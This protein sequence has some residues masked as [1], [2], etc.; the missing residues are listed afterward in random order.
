MLRQI[1]PNTQP[2]WGVMTLQHMVEHMADALRMAN[3]KDQY[4]QLITPEDKI[5]KM[6]AFILSDKP[7]REN[8]PNPLLPKVPGPC[9]NGSLSESIEELEKEI[10]D[11][12]SYFEQHPDARLLNPFFGYLNFDLYL[13]LLAKHARH[14]LRQFGFEG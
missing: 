10:D 3:G 5:E 4:T 1:P 12:F 7:F 14:H 13:R 11:F 6:Q 8:T 2:L 9:R